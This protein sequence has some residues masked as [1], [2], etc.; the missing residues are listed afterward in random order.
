MKI[1]ILA[2]I[3]ISIIIC[4]GCTNSD[5]SKNT[6]SG[7]DNEE[8]T[9]KDLR[10]GKMYRWIK[11]GKQIWMAENLNYA[12]HSGS[13]IFNDSIPNSMT[14]GRLYNWNAA[15][16][17]CPEGWHLPSDA[18]WSKLIRFLSGYDPAGNKLKI[19][20]PKYWKRSTFIPANKSGFS[21]LPGGGRYVNGSYS[22]AG[23]TAYFWTSTSASAIT[24]FC[25]YLFY[26]KPDVGKVNKNK[27]HAFS[28]RCIKD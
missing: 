22:I 26:N 25:R 12:T 15:L 5:V 11:I 6:S 10:D 27:E 8:G 17:A 18:D 7:Y 9:F 23:E 16:T 4:S 13:W 28:C 19:S 20:E 3:I 24:A 2:N 14:F 21:A 1:F